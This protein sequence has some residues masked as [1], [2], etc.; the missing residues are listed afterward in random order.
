MRERRRPIPIPLAYSSSP[1]IAVRGSHP[2]L[3]PVSLR[4][5][6][7]G[8]NVSIFPPPFFAHSQKKER[9]REREKERKREREREK[10]EREYS[11]YALA[12]FPRNRLFFFRVYT[13]RLGGAT[14]S[15]K[16]SLRIFVNMSSCVEISHEMS[17]LPNNPCDSTQE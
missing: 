9:E 12:E 11:L 13:E 17:M 3:P 1:C 16:V 15:S 6:I 4:K 7:G 5:R 2:F 14:W 8:R 10:G